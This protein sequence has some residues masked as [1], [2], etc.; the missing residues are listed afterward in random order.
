MMLFL[1]E[2]ENTREWAFIRE[3]I[4]YRYLEAREALD[5][6][7]DIRRQELRWWFDEEMRAA[8]EA[9]WHGPD[10]A[11]WSSDHKNETGGVA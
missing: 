3:P 10:Q 9:Y 1:P 6:E 7:Y 11:I 8:T 2:I 5:I 4:R